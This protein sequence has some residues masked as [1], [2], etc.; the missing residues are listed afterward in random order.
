MVDKKE[1]KNEADNNFNLMKEDYENE[2]WKPSSI[3]KGSIKSKLLRV[4][5]RPLKRKYLLCMKS[6][7]DPENYEKCIV[8]F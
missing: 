4:G 7:L 2:W 6:D 8:F 1:E 3:D 5:C